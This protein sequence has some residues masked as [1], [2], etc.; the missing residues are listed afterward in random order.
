MR[1]PIP[2]W[3][4]V[5]RWEATTR[6]QTTLPSIGT[7]SEWLATSRSIT[8]AAPGGGPALVWTKS[9]PL[10]TF[11]TIAECELPATLSLQG[12]L[13]LKRGSGFVSTSRSS[14]TPGSTLRRSRSLA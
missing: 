12:S 14:A 1:T 7:V 4:I 11:N 8:T 5:R 6:L 10:D 3:E 2:P 13:L 9:P